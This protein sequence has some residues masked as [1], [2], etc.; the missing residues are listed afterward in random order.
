MYVLMVFGGG[1]FDR[2]ELRV[3]VAFP[4]DASWPPCPAV[5]SAVKAEV[6]RPWCPAFIFLVSKDGTLRSFCW[7]NPYLWG[8]AVP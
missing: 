5:L 2:K 8:N 4:K 3:L 1:A 7:Q 6:A